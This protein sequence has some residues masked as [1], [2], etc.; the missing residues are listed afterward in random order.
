MSDRKSWTVKNEAI[1]VELSPMM[2][3]TTA[4]ETFLLNLQEQAKT[5]T[6][7][8]EYTQ[9]AHLVSMLETNAWRAGF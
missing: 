9:L 5:V 4:E 3:L 1:L 7:H 6:P 2:D 8:Y